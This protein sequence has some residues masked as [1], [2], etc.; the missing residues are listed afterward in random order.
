MSFVSAPTACCRPPPALPPPP[1]RSPS[2]RA[3]PPSL[4]HALTALLT[5]QL[6]GRPRGTYLECTSRGGL[7]GTT[8]C[9]NPA[10]QP[11]IATPPPPPPRPP[12]HRLLPSLSPSTSSL[13]SSTTSSPPPPSPTSLPPCSPSPRHVSK[14]H[15]IGAAAEICTHTLEQ[16]RLLAAIITSRHENHLESRFWPARG[17]A[18]VEGRLRDGDIRL[19][20]LPSLDGGHPRALSRVGRAHEL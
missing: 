16:P 15:R 13:T 9:C 17:P 3:L 19:R 12:P 11:S 4:M 6:L 5:L 7:K 14:P 10:R 1:R 2:F 18:V 20:G 8:R